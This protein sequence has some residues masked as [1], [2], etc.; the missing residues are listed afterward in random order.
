M[1]VIQAFNRQEAAKD[2]FDE[3]NVAYREAAGVLSTTELRFTATSFLAGVAAE[4]AAVRAAGG[5]E[6]L[7][8]E[9]FVTGL[10]EPPLTAPDAAAT[11]EE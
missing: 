11:E 4:Q 10:S 2:E 6:P 3:I 7:A 5:D 1:G 9:P 8:P